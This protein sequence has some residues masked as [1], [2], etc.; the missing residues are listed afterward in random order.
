MKL[1]LIAGL[2][3]T[4]SIVSSGLTDSL[5]MKMWIP[6]N[7]D[8]KFIFCLIYLSQIVIAF[9]IIV[10]MIT[11]DCYITGLMQQ[12]CAQLEIIRH[13]LCHITVLFKEDDEKTNNFQIEFKIRDCIIH[14]SYMYL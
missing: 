6:Y 9:A 4:L 13:R 14:H 10:L 2:A 12:I 11:I 3:S 1:F 7:T 8:S 5:P